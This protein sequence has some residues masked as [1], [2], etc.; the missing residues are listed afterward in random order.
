MKNLIFRM[1]LLIC[2][3][4]PVWVFSQDEIQIEDNVVVILKDGSQMSGRVVHKDTEAI[5]LRNSAGLEIKIPISSIR[6]IKLVEKVSETIFSRVDPNYSR[7][8][9]APT[10][11]PLQKGDGYFSDHY[12]F[13]P[14]VA[15]GLSNNV[16]LMG[17]FTIIPGLNLGRQ[18]FYLAPRVGA[19]F[20]E[21]FA[22][23]TGA[24]MLTFDRKNTFG[25]T[26][27]TGTFGTPDKSATL[28]IGFLFGKA[29]GEA[30]KF[31][32][33]PV[34][35]WGGNLRL[36]NGVAL[37]SEN[38]S[39]FGE[40]ISIGYLPFTVAL[41]FFSERIAVDAGFVIIGKVIEHGFPIPWL[42][43]VYNFGKK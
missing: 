32:K 21:Q 25:I 23:S 26:F 14:S 11:R 9:F 20:S 35:M 30:V 8:L 6:T 40:D 15:Y 38:W 16:S 39:V 19:N 18:L 1:M 42:S 2:C 43:F 4:L 10:G 24:I 41:R 29:E 7:L 12:I 22:L 5:T 33:K 27:A 28:G 34:V 37:V 31:A 13:F 36:S 17:G 3:S